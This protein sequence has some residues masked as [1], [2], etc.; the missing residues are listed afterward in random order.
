METK[1]SSVSQFNHI[2]RHEIRD[3]L[4]KEELDRLINLSKNYRKQ[5][6][7][8]S[9]ISKILMY[10]ATISAFISGFYDLKGLILITGILNTISGALHSHVSYSKKQSNSCLK[11]IDH[12]LDKLNIKVV[13]FDHDTPPLVLT[14]KNNSETSS[15]D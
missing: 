4:L 6:N 12:L 11:Q 7:T 14:P 13:G 8:C 1:R 2:V 15:N 10:M 9:Y 5:A 3:N